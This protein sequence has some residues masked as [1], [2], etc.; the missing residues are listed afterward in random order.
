MN[1]NKLLFVGLAVVVVVLAGVALLST[2]GNNTTNPVTQ[3][4]GTNTV[5]TA[6]PEQMVTTGVTVTAQG[7]EPKTVTIKAGTKVLWTNNSGATVTVTSAL[8]PTHLLFP[9]LN[10]GE[11]SDGSTVEAVFDKPGTYKYHNHLDPSQ[12][13]TVIVE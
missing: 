5:P 12:T 11:F 8:H 13:G 3:N 7:F 2:K 10:L 4:Q 1:N 9:F 6:A